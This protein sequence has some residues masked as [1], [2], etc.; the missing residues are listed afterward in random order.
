RTPEQTRR[1]VYELGAVRGMLT[2]RVPILGTLR[3]LDRA[4]NDGD[5]TN[6]GYEWDYRR[7]IEGGTAATAIW[8]FEGL[9]GEDFGETLPLEMTIRVFR[10]HKGNIE[11]G[12]T[13]TIEL[14]KP[15]PLDGQ[16]HPIARDGGL[17][18]EAMSF[19]ARDYE[20]YQPRIS[21]IQTVVTPEG[22]RK[23]VD[24]FEELVDP[25]TGALEV[26]MRC[27]DGGQYFG[28]A[29]ADLYIRAR[30][31]P[32]WVNFVKGYVSIWLQMVVVTGFG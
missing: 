14:V 27:L 24:I 22:Q 16:G 3:F 12:L 1:G 9:R 32:F 25:E 21:R 13:G 23:E 29:A 5:G 7:Y 20:A 2:A 11:E 4:G 6:V 19:T 31:E 15:A 28:M 10:T 8:R 30:N 18:T 17:R 26:W